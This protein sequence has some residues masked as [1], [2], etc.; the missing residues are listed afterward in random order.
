MEW[1][2]YRDEKGEFQEFP[3]VIFRK[4]CLILQFNFFDN[5]WRSRSEGIPSQEAAK[6]RCIIHYFERITEK[7]CF[8]TF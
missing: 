8:F 4:F 3:K 1:Q 5:F 6:I 2:V 7:G